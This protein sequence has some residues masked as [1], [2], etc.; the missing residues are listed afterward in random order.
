MTAKMRRVSWCCRVIS[1]LTW[2]GKTSC[3]SDLGC[4][5][6]PLSACKPSLLLIHRAS[7]TQNMPIRR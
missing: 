4:I 1:V 2:L 3:R 7:Y 6:H 5:M